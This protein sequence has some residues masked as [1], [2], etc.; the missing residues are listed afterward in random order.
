MEN[1]ENQVREFEINDE[2]PLLNFKIERYFGDAIFAAG[3]GIGITGGMTTSYE[4]IITGGVVAFLGG[5]Y[6]LST[7]VL[8]KALNRANYKRSSS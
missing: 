5:L 1:L 6:R 2:L 8:E 3:T 4:L 7:C